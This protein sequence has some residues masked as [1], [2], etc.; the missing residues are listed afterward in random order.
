MRRRSGACVTL[1]SSAPS[2]FIPGETL[3]AIRRRL[4]AAASQTGTALII[5]RKEQSVYFWVDSGEG[6]RRRGSP[7]KRTA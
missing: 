1:T 6:R 2:S 7:P 3:S 5:K 4:G